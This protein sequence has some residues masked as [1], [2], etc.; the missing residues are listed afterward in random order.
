MKLKARMCDS[1]KKC[2]DCQ[3]NYREEEK[4]DAD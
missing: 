1:L 3:L 4:N 2:G